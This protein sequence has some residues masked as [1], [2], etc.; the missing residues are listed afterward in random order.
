[1]NGHNSRY[2]FRTFLDT[3]YQFHQHL[4]VVVDGPVDAAAFDKVAL[5]F[6]V[7]EVAVGVLL[8]VHVV[9]DRLICRQVVEF[10]KNKNKKQI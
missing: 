4:K 9:V 7:E 8:A 3:E 5:A 10:E 2:N 1:M 6:A